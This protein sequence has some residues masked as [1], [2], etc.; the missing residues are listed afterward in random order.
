MDDFDTI[1]ENEV[2]S[3][4]PRDLLGDSNRSLSKSTMKAQK[5]A[6]S[7]LNKY[8]KHLHDNHK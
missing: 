2:M 7:C 3:L 4:V 6:L 5:S 1:E 8:V